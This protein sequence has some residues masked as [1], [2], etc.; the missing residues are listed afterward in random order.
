MVHG[1]ESLW[2]RSASARSP[3]RDGSGAIFGSFSGLTKGTSKN[4]ID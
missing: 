4:V 2:R 1:A 3:E